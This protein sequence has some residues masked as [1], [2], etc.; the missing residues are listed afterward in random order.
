MGG[1]VIAV[2]TKSIRECA[3]RSEN[4]YRSAPD[5][6]EVRAFR[7]LAR[8]DRRYQAVAT[9]PKALPGETAGEADFQRPV[10]LAPLRLA[11]ARRC[12]HAL[13]ALLP[14]RRL[15]LD[16]QLR[17]ARCGKVV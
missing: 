17:Q 8:P 13:A 2:S 9:W 3:F 6:P 7:A 16:S 11:I 12:P 5:D 15:A 14:A 4:A 10:E 1:S